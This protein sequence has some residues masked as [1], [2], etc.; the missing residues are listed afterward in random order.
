VLLRVAGVTALRLIGQKMRP[1]L[2]LI[3]GA[4]EPG[5]AVAAAIAHDLGPL[6]TVLGFVDDELSPM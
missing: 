1:G 5:T 4:S 2:V 6:L 3:V